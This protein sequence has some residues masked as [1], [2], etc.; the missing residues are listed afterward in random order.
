MHKISVIRWKNYMLEVELSVRQVLCIESQG[1]AAF[2]IITGDIYTMQL[3]KQER[4]V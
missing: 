3:G 2:L 4:D 1:F